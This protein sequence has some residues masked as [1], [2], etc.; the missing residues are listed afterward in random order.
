MARNI[1]QYFQYDK[2][3]FTFPHGRHIIVKGYGIY[4]V[5]KI[6]EDRYAHILSG[7]TCE[8]RKK[9]IAF[10][11]KWAPGPSRAQPAATKAPQARAR[12]GQQSW[13]PAKM[14]GRPI[15]VEHY[16]FY[17]TVMEMARRPLRLALW[18]WRVGEL[19]HR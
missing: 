1:E 5:K 18:R 17:D 6:F 19:R 14:S 13:R 11:A 16:L 2:R 4:M 12:S 8:I 15:L 7:I 9:D 3:G 10:V